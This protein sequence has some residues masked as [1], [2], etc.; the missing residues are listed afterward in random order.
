[1]PLFSF[2]RSRI[3]RIM[4]F[5]PPSYYDDKQN[6]YTAIR[7]VPLAS[8]MGAEI[9]DVNIATISDEQFEQ[10]RDALFRYKMI[11]FRKQR[12]MTIA[13]QEALTLRFGEFGTDA[14]TQGMEGHPNVQRVLKEADSVVD[15]VFGD[16]WHTDSPFLPQPPAIS[17]LHSIDV[18]PYGGD[19]WWS[20]AQLAYEFLSDKMKDVIADLKVHMSAAFVLQNV[21]KGRSGES[22]LQQG[23]MELSVNQQKMVDGSFHPIVRTHPETGQKSLYCDRTYSLGIEGMTQEESKPLLDFLGRHATREE[24]ICRLRWEPDMLVIWDNRLCLHKAF[25]DYDGYRRELIRTI[26]NGEVPA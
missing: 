25:N 15:W 23:D 18:P 5:Y 21:N 2:T 19:T 1:M 8:A 14:Y 17:L 3:T 24:F 26:V 12:G 20:N 6:G 4:Q 11:Y 9:L 16:G 22:K 7:T 10:V 13:D